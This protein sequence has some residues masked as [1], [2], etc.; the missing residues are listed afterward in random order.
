MPFRADD[1]RC[2]GAAARIH[3]QAEKGFRMRGSWA[4]CLAAGLAGVLSGGMAW[5]QGFLVSTNAPQT[6]AGQLAHGRMEYAATCSSCHGANLDDG[7]FGPP[8]KGVGFEARWARSD[9]AWLLAYIQSTMPPSGPGTLS[10]DVYRDILAYILQRNATDST[11]G[12]RAGDGSGS[13]MAYDAVYSAAIA[14]RQAKLD[15]MRLVTDAMLEAPGDGEWLAWRRTLDAQAY[16]PLTQIKKRNVGLLRQ[17]WSWSLPPSLNET[18]PLVH[19]GIMFVAS[20]NMVQAL[21]AATGDLM[22]QYLRPLPAEFN[23]GRDE[24]VKTLALYGHKLF[25]PTADG[26]LVALDARTGKVAWDVRV[27]SEAEGDF[28]GRPSGEALHLHGGPIAVR[29]KVFLGVTLGVVNKRGGNFI[30]AVDAET[31]KEAWRF[32]TVDQRPAGQDSWN[33]WPVGS[34]FG[35]GVWTAG[36]YDPELN[37]VYFG[38]GNTYDAKVLLSPRQE[39]GPWNAGLY[40]DSTVALDADTGR[41]VWYYQ[42]LNRD[43]WDLDWAFERTLMTLTIGGRA[44]KAVVTGGK[45]ALFDAVDRTTGEYLFSRDMGLQGLVTAIDAKTG[46]KTTNPALEPEAGKSKPMCPSALGARNWP[47]TAYN[48]TNGLLYVPML[49]SCSNYTYAPRSDADTANGGIDIHF[50]PRPRP[51]SDGNFGRVTAIEMATGRVAWMDR[52]RFAVSSS[53]LV[54]AGGLLFQGFVDRTFQAYDAATG[55]VLWR[56]RLNAS[57]SSSP[58]TY[59]VNGRQYVAV[60]SGGGGAVDAHARGLA[61]EVTNPAGANTIVVFRLPADE[62]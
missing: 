5:S 20:G 29:G 24:R 22:W 56:T 61:P 26:H 60:I 52:Q 55:K 39:K 6:T 36:S 2:I 32:D 44:R 9:P 23:N 54:T 50:T 47:A 25:V 4:A 46:V 38:T 37:L 19:D 15:A 53:A 17:I 42:H 1:Q 62:R 35:G 58:I 12:M 21:D 13:R 43:V 51:D 30:L 7:Q 27:Y 48:P 59:M 33:G 16:S 34:R 14:R 49:E 57:P 8:L 3:M 28:R 31:G 11:R 40:T 45:I 18:T 41:L 10:A